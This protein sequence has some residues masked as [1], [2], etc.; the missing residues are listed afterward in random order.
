[1]AW[2]V[3]EDKVLASLDVANT[4]SERRRGLLGQD[5]FDGAL[6][7]RPARSVHTFGMRFALDVAIV[8][9]EGTVVALF[10]MKQRRVS[11]PRRRGVA[12]VEAS[13]G[14]FERWGLRVGDTLVF[15]E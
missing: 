5:S 4:R 15:R 11:R 7:I 6:L 8:D 9:E 14:S 2:L 1:M 10:A 12:I 3:H 13:A